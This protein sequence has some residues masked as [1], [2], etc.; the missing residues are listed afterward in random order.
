MPI[1]KVNPPIGRGAKSVTLGGRGAKCSTF[2]GRSAEFGPRREFWLDLDGEH[3]IA[4]V[5]KR[6][7]G[8]THTLG[9]LVEGLAAATK[10][11]NLTLTTGTGLQHAVV[12]FDT[13]NLF[14]WLDLSLDSAQGSFAE[15]QRSLLSKWKLESKVIEPTFWHPVGSEPATQKSS[16]FSINP[17]DLDAQDWGRL[18]GLDI[19]SEPMG[20]LLNDLYLR[21]QP[22]PGQKHSAR[23]GI[24]DML[25][26]L[27]TDTALRADYSP[28]TVRGIRQR[29]SALAQSPLFDSKVPDWTNALH[30]G[31]VAVFLLG[32]VPEDLR[33]LL[34]FLVIRRLLESRSS[35]S[36]AAKH[37]MLIGAPP[38]SGQIPPAWLII[39]EAQ[40]ILPSRSATA[41]NEIL[42]RYVREGRNF[43]L[44][45]ALS[46]QQPNSIDPKVMA[47]VDTL[48][49][50]NLTVRTDVN[51]IMSNLK[52]ADP[53]SISVASRE[54][55]LAD[56]LRLLD[57]GQCM[58]SSVDSPRLVFCDVR[59]RVTLHGG[60]EG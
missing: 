12:I 48:I 8:K 6:G 58:I 54:I 3:V 11:E 38:A 17:A 2:I 51:Y 56:S 36:E 46:T 34:V 25:T 10:G 53:D 27:R 45:L 19:A 31:K 15:K 55:S 47:Q 37:A 9:V 21:V 32:R 13:L 52:S 18:F 40:N 42:T 26:V 7:S 20:Q 24:E 57:A 50:H 4:V 35:A 5:G 16:V 59:P 60:F 39:D 43:G 49:A 30:A 1:F 23:Y 44:S 29:L 41:A 33:S 14:Q 28:E 22:K